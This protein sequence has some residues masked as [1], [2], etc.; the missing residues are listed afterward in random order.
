[1][2]I[3]FT[4]PCLLFAVTHYVNAVVDIP[5]THTNSEIDGYIAAF[6][7]SSEFKSG[8]SDKTEYEA[9]GT[10]DHRKNKNQ[11]IVIYKQ[12]YEK[13]SGDKSEDK[14]FLHARHVNEF[15]GP[16]YY[17]LFAQYQSNESR[18]LD[19][20]ALLGTGVRHHMVE[21]DRHNFY[22]GYGAYYTWEEYEDEFLHEEDDYLR[23]SFYSAYTLRLK[24]DVDFIQRNYYQPRWDH[25][26][27]VYVHSLF[28]L[29]F[30]LMEP[31]TFFTEVVYAYDSDPFSD[32]KKTDIHSKFG[33]TLWLDRRVKKS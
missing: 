9:K 11:N 6:D 22:M 1:M 4:L 31:L 17:E 8:N 27:D 26:S 20:R 3:K 2:N 16:L 32:N 14:K 25:A 7:F 19:A 24:D 28:R 10:F 18:D 13:V 23:G 21:T 33:F 12:E 15:K 5:H 30:K 29:Q